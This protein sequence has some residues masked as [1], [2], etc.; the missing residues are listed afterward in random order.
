MQIS[1]HKSLCMAGW[2]RSLDFVG[3]KVIVVWQSTAIALNKVRNSD[4]ENSSVL[5]LETNKAT[6]VG[7]NQ[8]CHCCQLWGLANAGK[9]SSVLCLSLPRVPWFCVIFYAV[10][11]YLDV[12][13]WLVSCLYS[14]GNVLLCVIFCGAFFQFSKSIMI[15]IH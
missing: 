1:L 8:V 15:Y 13:L 5:L 11:H 7:V 4:N 6:I 14:V 3:K 9:L 2:L 12:I 10:S